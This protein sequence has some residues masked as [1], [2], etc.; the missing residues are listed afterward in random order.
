MRHIEGARWE[1]NTLI[2]TSN[3]QQGS[4]FI[5]LLKLTHAVQKHMHA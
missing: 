4:L 2:K 1:K 3:K 5:C